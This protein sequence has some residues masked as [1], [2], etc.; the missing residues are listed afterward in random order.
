MRLTEAEQRLLEEAEQRLREEWRNAPP[1]EGEGYCAPLMEAI[2]ACRRM[3]ATPTTVTDPGLVAVIDRLIAALVDLV[4]AG[5]VWADYRPTEEILPTLRRLREVV[6]VGVPSPE[7]DALAREVM[8]FFG[9]AP[10]PS[11]PITAE[12]GSG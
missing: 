8:Q 4:P 7:F 1:I 12:R 5:A 9:L 6:A 10:T 3:L 2:D 11:A